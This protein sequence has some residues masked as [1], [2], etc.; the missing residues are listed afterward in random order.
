MSHQSKNQSSKSYRSDANRRTVE[1][2][3]NGG[4][5]CAIYAKITGKLGDNRMKI[6]YQQGSRGYE[7]IAKIRGL[8]RRKGQ[9]P[10]QTNDIVI[11]TPR[12]FERGEDAKKHFDLIGVLTSKQACDLKKRK[13]IPDYFMNDV[14]TNSSD[15]QKKE[16]VD[17]FDFDYDDNIKIDDI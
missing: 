11:I 17:A 3:M 7:G 12:E 6:Y 16:V 10:I 9:V 14:G 15:F 2:S 1:S 8:L 4:I 13:E 5:E